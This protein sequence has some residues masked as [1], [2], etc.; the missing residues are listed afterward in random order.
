[1]DGK[2]TLLNASTDP[3]RVDARIKIENPA[4]IAG[5]PLAMHGPS[6]IARLDWVTAEDELSVLH[7][8]LDTLLVYA[9]HLSLESKPIGILMKVHDRRE[10]LDAP[11]RFTLGWC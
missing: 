8:H 5:F 6:G 4:V 11:C 3:R 1:M 7:G 10:I 9:G 2:Q